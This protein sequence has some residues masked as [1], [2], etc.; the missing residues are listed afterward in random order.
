MARSGLAV[1]MLCIVS[2]LAGPASAR[3]PRVFTRE[4]Y[5][6]YFSP[7]RLQSHSP[8]YDSNGHLE[9]VRNRIV[10]VGGKTFLE[11]TVR[12]LDVSPNYDTMSTAP[13]YKIR[14][15]GVSRMVWDD[16]RAA[17]MFDYSEADFAKDNSEVFESGNSRIEITKGDE[18]RGTLHEFYRAADARAGRDVDA[19]DRV[20]R[21]D[22]VGTWSMQ[23]AFVSARDFDVACEM[24]HLPTDRVERHLYRK[25]DLIG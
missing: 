13:Y 17:Y 21:G 1:L 10:S 18:P 19:L 2:V 24:T 14:S 20:Y 9:V 25:L 3:E 12:S 11:Q 23:C 4:D 6:A 5:V 7:G 22:V 8:Y 15:N 16:R